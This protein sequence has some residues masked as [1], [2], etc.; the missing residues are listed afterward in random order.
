MPGAPPLRTAKE[1]RPAP[2]PGPNTDP[3]TRKT[4]IAVGVTAGAVILLS[5]IVAAPD[6]FLLVFSGILVAVL[7]RSLSNWVASH[8]PLSE[9]GSLAAVILLIIALFGLL[10]WSL[11]PEVSR[12][13]DQLFQNLPKMAEQ[14]KERLSEYS[15]GRQLFSQPEG[16]G[17]M[18]GSSGWITRAAGIFSTTLG[19]LASL[20]IVLF[21]GLHMAIDPASYRNGVMRLFPMAKRDRIREVLD[22]IGESLRW[23][24]I[25]RM[26]AMVVI[27][28]LTTGG[29]LFLGVQP[30]LALGVAAGIL[31]F[32]PYLGPFLAVVPAVLIAAGQGTDKLVSVALLYLV[33]Q[34]IDN[35]FVTPTVEKRA[36]HLPPA[37]T[38][39]VQLLL[40]VLV[41]ALGVML[42]SPL[43]ACVLVIIKLLYVE[44]A[45]GDSAPTG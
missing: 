34:W 5:L 29:L 36:V 39:S 23:W 45:L 2:S 4:F 44:D 37:L 33:V 3:F 26:I 32:V 31:N 21:T 16:A 14:A 20:I 41:G 7:L 15:W 43:T 12:Q 35:Y 42:A 40:G 19:L 28:V 30:A 6:V 22:Q 1:D 25:A 17:P 24:M 38:V 8:T 18:A 27:G 10:G 13:V 9:K 11:A